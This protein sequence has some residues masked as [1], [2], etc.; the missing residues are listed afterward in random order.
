MEVFQLP[1]SDLSK[2]AAVEL[3]WLKT[4]CEERG[5][6]Q[7]VTSVSLSPPAGSPLVAAMLRNSLKMLLAGGK[8][9]RKSRSSGESRQQRPLW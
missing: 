5:E 6:E 7:R 3:W 9:N 1:W 4:F 2:H 8:S